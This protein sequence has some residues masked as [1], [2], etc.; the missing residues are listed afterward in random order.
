MK[1]KIEILRAI[2]FRWSKKYF[3]QYIQL[4]G[5]PANLGSEGYEIWPQGKL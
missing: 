1:S 3:L 4:M 2:F 5:I